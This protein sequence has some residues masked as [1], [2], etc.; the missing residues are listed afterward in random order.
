MRA[1]A[2][3][4]A[5]CVPVA[6]VR[7]APADPATQKARELFEHAEALYALT[8]YDE[9]LAEYERAYETK[10]L[11]GF[12]FNIGQCQRN[13]GHW[14]K[15]AHFYHE[16]LERDPEA[17]NRKLVE[18]LAGEMDQQVQAH[19]ETASLEVVQPP[20]LVEKP[21]EKPPEQPIVVE[22]PKVEEKPARP[23]WKRWWVWA[24]AGGAAAVVALVVGLAVGLRG[25]TLPQGSLST[26]DVR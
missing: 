10:P 18:E 24:A 21:P 8:R 2:L 16:Y 6:G 19:P 22:K 1:L 14:A 9:A 26:I 15:A 23:L 7:A 25:P 11:P 4:V 5:L 20:P 12:L 3:A 13:L 17:R